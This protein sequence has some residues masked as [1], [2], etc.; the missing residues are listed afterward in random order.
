MPMIT[1]KNYVDVDVSYSY[2]ISTG[3]NLKKN[4]ILSFKEFKKLVFVKFEDK[5]T[6]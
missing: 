5:Q 4:S 1:L 6:K 3:C 2:E